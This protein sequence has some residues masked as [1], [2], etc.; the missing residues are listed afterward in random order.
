MQGRLILDTPE[1]VE[2]ARKMGVED[3]KQAYTMEEMAKGDVIFLCD[4][5]HRRQHAGRCTVRPGHDHNPYG[6]HAVV[7]THGS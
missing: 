4:R 2:R 7:I 1:K 5:R 6:G 3:P